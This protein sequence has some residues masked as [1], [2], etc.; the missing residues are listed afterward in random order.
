MVNI[1]LFFAQKTLFLGL[2]LTQKRFSRKQWCFRTLSCTQGQY[3][4]VLQ[5]C[6]DHKKEGMINLILENKC[7]AQD[8]E[9]EYEFIVDNKK[10]CLVHAPNDYETTIKRLCKSYDISSPLPS[11]EKF[12]IALIVLKNPA[13]RQMECADV[14]NDLK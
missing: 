4:K 12:I 6:K 3:D 5:F 14:L 2:F 9:R 10:L 7:S 1:W 13:T 11:I 8:C